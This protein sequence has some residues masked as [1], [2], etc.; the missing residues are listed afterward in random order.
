MRVV[1][2]TGVVLSAL[3]FSHGKL[4]W[5]REIWQAGRVVPIVS[6]ATISELCRVLAYPK[7]QLSAMEQEELLGDYLP[8]AE[9]IT[10]PDALPTLPECSDPADQKF[11]ILVHAADANCLVSGDRDLLQMAGKARYPI[12]SPSEFKQ[13][14]QS[15]VM[16][17]NEIHESPAAQ[18]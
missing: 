16:P 1:F 3:I 8:Y 15:R 18:Y 5:L 2:D 17:L 10:I 13:Q 6:R 11:I 14:W 4:A 9:V 12:F 7:F